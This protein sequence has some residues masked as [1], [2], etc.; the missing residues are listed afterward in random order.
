MVVAAVVVVVVAASVVVV[1][2]GDS[3]VVVVV[4]PAVV[5]VVVGESVVVVV[6][7]PDVVVVVVAIGPRLDRVKSAAPSNPARRSVKKVDRYST[8]GKSTSTLPIVSKNR[9]SFVSL[10][11][12]RAPR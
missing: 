9:S 2:V 4:A 12:N 1:V 11:E 7:G 6:V 3:V 8:D 10:L 5:V